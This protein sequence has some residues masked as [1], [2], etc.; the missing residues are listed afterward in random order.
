MD[1]TLSCTKQA[2][3]VL[4]GYFILG[5]S[6]LYKLVKEIGK[7]VQNFRTLSTEATKTFESSMES[8]LQME[9]IRKTQRELNDAF[10]F[11][12]S[13]NVDPD[14]EAF[15]TTTTSEKVG[16]EPILSRTDDDGTKGKK[17][18]RRRKKPTVSSSEENEE[19]EQQLRMDDSWET[20]NTGENNIPDLDMSYAFD[21]NAKSDWNLDSNSNDWFLESENQS[22]GNVDETVPA[23]AQSAARFQAQI[24]G[25]WND[26]ILGNEEQLSPL[27]KVMERLALLEEEKAAQVFRLEEEYRE[28]AAMEEKFYRQKRALLEDAAA[29]IQANVYSSMTGSAS[30]SSSSSAPT[31]TTSESNPFLQDAS[32]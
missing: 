3:I 31:T 18:I 8:Q 16:A 5:P 7:A 23:D 29:E 1:L 22:K 26:S 21:T 4:V 11:R 2:T 25:N 27:A 24:Q 20:A 17:R 30:S 15:T 28:R 14:D 12:R 19:T 6:D 13:I 32:S 9:E 10:S